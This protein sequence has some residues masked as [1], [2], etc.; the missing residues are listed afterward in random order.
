MREN[1]IQKISRTATAIVLL[2]LTT[3]TAWAED[4]SYRDDNDTQRTAT[5]VN[6]LDAN[7]LT[8]SDGWYMAADNLT[9]GSR[10]TI[11]GDVKLILKDDVTLH[12]PKGIS[13]EGD[14]SLTI[15]GQ[16]CGT[17]V[18]TIDGV[19]SY[20]AGIGA[21]TGSG[22]NCGTIT[23]CGGV[24]K[25]KG[26]SL[27]CDIGGFLS[28]SN[29]FTTGGTITISGGQVTANGGYGIG[30]FAALFKGD[31]TVT[32]GCTRLTDFITV[33]TLSFTSSVKIAN[34]K[35]LSD[36]TNIY[37]GTL[38]SEQIAAL[39]N[40]TLR[41][42]SLV[43]VSYIDMN[44]DEQQCSN[45]GNLYATA[46][47]LSAG[48]YVAEGTLNF[49][50]HVSVTGDVHI[51]LK[52]GAIVNIGTAESPIDGFGLGNEDANHS[53]SIYGQSTGTDN[54][55]LNVYSTRTSILALNGDVNC[56]SV[57]I[58]A[59]PSDNYGIWAIKS[60]VSGVGNINL[61]D[62]T[63]NTTGSYGFYAQ[64]DVSI[65]GGKVTATETIYGIFAT[66]G[67]VSISDGEVTAAGSGRGIF[68]ENGS[69]TITGGEV[70]ADGE[71][72]IGIDAKDGVTISGGVV[73]AKGS[74]Y[75]INAQNGDVNISGGQVIAQG[76]A[77]R[78]N[79]GI[80]ASR[81]ITLG[82]TRSPDFILASSYGVKYGSISIAEGKYFIDERGNTYSGTIAFENNACAIDDKYLFFPV[83]IDVT[84]LDM[85]G[86]QK[87]CPSYIPLT[88]TETT[89]TAD[90]YVAEGTVSFDHHVSV[91]GDAHIV[92]KDGA[93]VNIGTAESPVDGFG[94]GD[95]SA[96]H[97]ISI[98]GQS[99]GTDNGQLNVYA[100]KTCIW[101]FNGDFNC[102][103]ARVTATPISSY[104]FGI[105]AINY[106][107]GG[108]GNIKLKD[109][110]VNASGTYG[111]YAQNGNATIDGGKVTAT[112]SAY[113]YGLFVHD[114][115]VTIS[116]GE[117]TAT[118]GNG[119]IYAE[120]G[121]VTISGGKVT[122]TGN[123]LH[124]IHSKNG[125]VT[126]SG[127]EV[128]STGSIFGIYAQTGDVNIS[129]GKVTAIGN[130]SF[131]KSIGTINGN[132]ILDW[133]SPSDFIYADGYSCNNGSISIAEDKTFIDEDGTTYSGPIALENNVCAIDGKTLRPYSSS[134]LVLADDAD[135]TAVISKFELSPAA[136][137]T[138]TAHGTRCACRSQSRSRVPPSREPTSARSAAPRSIMA[139]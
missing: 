37:S 2:M 55:Q 14:N 24:V 31:A 76:K 116:D 134:M 122:A 137:S 105:W 30:G 127:G 87:T 124:G 48:W 89:L 135:N 33:N 84:Y 35:E 88:G 107:G 45:F 39:N 75:G 9:I 119:G 66:N 71:D 21:A 133:T 27:A 113:N 121:S 67:S 59:S 15:Y 99:T 114:G 92:L 91:A 73:S 108:T 83:S 97:S 49:D 109:A 120:E 72:H 8:I 61:K 106:K 130:N 5:G 23:I 100:T 85:N 94:I 22:N 11:S 10:V 102:S 126:I 110:T 78:Y 32:L 1:I 63:V 38:N 40:K 101:T 96:N 42:H 20:C 68:A 128:R 3:V 4:V 34:E 41:L 25:A 19:D 115:I 81:N 54:G 52:N 62:A 17:G 90:W 50:H 86:E 131:N 136:P 26:G 74:L 69:I 111:L 12:I 58:T 28:F 64:G 132:I 93:V 29:E 65:D 103:S 44:G 36:G 43:T 125:A 47:T 123:D 118:G 51:I 13:V 6:M 129:G 16:D 80:Y 46:T 60:N 7:S 117:V 112:G 104:A 79:K 18:L 56:S 53:I 57:R 82:W 139:R 138:K 98:Y 77:E 95:D 70:T